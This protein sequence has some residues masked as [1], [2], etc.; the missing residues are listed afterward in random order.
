MVV[1]RSRLNRRYLWV[2]L[3]W[4]IRR[5]AKTSSSSVYEAVNELVSSFTYQ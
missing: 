3:A 4:P 1:G 2:N 5:W